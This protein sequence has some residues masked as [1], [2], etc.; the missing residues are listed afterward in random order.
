MVNCKCK[1]VWT[2]FICF[3]I[4]MVLKAFL[5]QCEENGQSGTFCF[6]ELNLQMWTSKALGPLLNELYVLMINAGDQIAFL[7]R[8]KALYVN[9]LNIIGLLVHRISFLFILLNDLKEK[10]D[11]CNGWT[12]GI[13]VLRKCLLLLT[14]FW[15]IVD[16]NTMPTQGKRQLSSGMNW[17]LN[18]VV[19]RTVFCSFPQLRTWI[20]YIL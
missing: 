3:V 18:L 13:F 7:L 10:W 5:S 20:L 16:N 1:C 15:S 19:A 14:G 4:R 17:W 2:S 6:E 8:S 9:I 11:L 12:P